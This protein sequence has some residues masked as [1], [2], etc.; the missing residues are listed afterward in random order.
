MHRDGS[1]DLPRPVLAVVSA[2]GF[3]VNEG[4]LV[5]HQEL[6]EVA[7]GA[8]EPVLGSAVDVDVRELLLRDGEHQ[9][10]RVGRVGVLDFEEELAFWGPLDLRSKA[11]Y[12]DLVV[13]RVGGLVLPRG[14]LLV[15]AKPF[16]RVLGEGE[17]TE[18][19]PIEQKRSGCRSPRVKPP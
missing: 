3:A 15:R 5:L 13:G 11:F 9:L 6:G 4:D 17:R 1:A 16:A 12:L 8:D 7:T 2:G 10:K 19:L 14:Q 18:W